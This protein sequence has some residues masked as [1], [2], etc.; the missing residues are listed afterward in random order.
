MA[1]VRIILIVAVLAVMGVIGYMQ[2]A[3]VSGVSGA[4]DAADGEDYAALDESADTKRSTASSGYSGGNLIKSTKTTSRVGGDK[5]ITIQRKA[6]SLW[7]R[8]RMWFGYQPEDAHRR[9][10]ARLKAQREAEARRN[11][12]V[13]SATGRKESTARVSSSGSS[14]KRKAAPNKSVASALGN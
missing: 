5:T 13:N 7:T 1:Q 10:F 4:L 14:V 6:P 2:Y 9:D 11:K 8:I 12:G 3:S